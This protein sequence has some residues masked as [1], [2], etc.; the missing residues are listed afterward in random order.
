[1]SKVT[2]RQHQTI[3]DIAIQETGSVDAA[4]AIV[5]RNGMDINTPLSVGQ[6]LHVDAPVADAAV[7]EHYR[8]QGIRPVN[9]LRPE[10][11]AK[12]PADYDSDD[13]DNK[14]FDTWP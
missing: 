1:M 8:Q 13:F 11:Q 6:V 12:L 5:R 10:E 3:W 2:V 9:G 4:F 14:D 7:V